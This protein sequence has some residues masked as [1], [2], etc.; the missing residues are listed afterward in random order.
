MSERFVDDRRS[1]SITG[2]FDDHGL[3]GKALAWLKSCLPDTINLDILKTLPL[4]IQNRIS[5]FFRVQSLD[6]Y[7]AVIQKPARA[8]AAK[9]NQVCV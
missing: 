2:F 6:L 8:L 7:S 4:S 1:Q 5:V 9:Y 3:R